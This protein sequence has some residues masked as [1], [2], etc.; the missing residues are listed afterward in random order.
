MGLGGKTLDRYT[1]K[2]FCLLSNF[3][4][5][6]PVSEVVKLVVWN[7]KRSDVHACLLI[8]AAAGLASC[9]FADTDIVLMLNEMP[10]FLFYSWHVLA[11]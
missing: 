9:Y 11:K 4:K 3:F 5:K 1:K 6:I 8:L 2:S 10:R 7:D